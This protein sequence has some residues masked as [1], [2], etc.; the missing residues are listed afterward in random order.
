MTERC[1]EKTE[2]WSLINKLKILALNGNK[3]NARRYSAQS[4]K[5]LHIQDFHTIYETNVCFVTK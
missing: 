1:E 3:E 2:I 5:M 4:Y